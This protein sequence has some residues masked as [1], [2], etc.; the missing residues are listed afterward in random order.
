MV[1]VAAAISVLII[2]DLDK[3]IPK[4]LQDPGLVVV[5]QDSK[6]AQTL[7]EEVIKKYD[8][9]EKELSALEN[10]LEFNINSTEKRYAFVI[11]YDTKKIVAHPNTELLGQDSFA[12]INASE[13]EESILE[14][15]K[16]ND[17]HWVYYD[18]TNP[19]TGNEEP[20]TSWFKLHDGLI[21]GSGFYN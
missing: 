16:N 8:N 5:S 10:F 11:D 4:P 18:F 21:F 15:L 20:K 19:E 12:L 1:I 3:P 6:L 2:Y 17:G 13:S 9:E 7:V 14:N